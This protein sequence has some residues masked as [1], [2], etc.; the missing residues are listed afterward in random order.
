MVTQARASLQS[1]A[2]SNHHTDTNTL[3]SAWQVSLLGLKFKEA[4]SN[5]EVNLIRFCIRG[6]RLL[7]AFI[8]GECNSETF[9]VQQHT[10]RA[11]SMNLMGRFQS[12]VPPLFLPTLFRLSSNNVPEGWRGDKLQRVLQAQKLAH[13][14]VC[15]VL[16]D[17][18]PKRLMPKNS[19]RMNT[20]PKS[21]AI[22]EEP[23]VRFLVIPGTFFCNA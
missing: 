8:Y 19:P 9:K 3:L 21:M 10:N 12:A 16:G 2:T 17:Q 7:T 15:S 4:P 18:P 13:L 11:V 14:T 22:Q 23:K 6:S 5:L 1:L 20:D